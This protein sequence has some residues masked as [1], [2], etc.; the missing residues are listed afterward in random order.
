MARRLDYDD[1]HLFMVLVT[2]DHSGNTW[3]HIVK[4][5]NVDSWRSSFDWLPGVTVRARPL[6][7]A[8]SKRVWDHA[9][10][11]VMVR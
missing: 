8:L 11:L 9:P 6:S 3:R 4:A 7:K 2:Y 1:S 10:T 5:R